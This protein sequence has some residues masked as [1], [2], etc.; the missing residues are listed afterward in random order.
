[1]TALIGTDP[2]NTFTSTTLKQ[3]KAFGL[4]DRYIDASGNEFVFVLASGVITVYDTVWINSAYTAAAI[5]PA[6]AVTPGAVGFAQTAFADG[7]Y[8]FVMTR[9]VPT[10]RVGAS[11]NA[12][13]PLYTS[14][15]A[16]VLDDS[17]LSASHYQVQGVILAQSV[18]ASIST[19]TAVASFPLIRRPQA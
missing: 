9:G 19:G 8:G 4:G 12:N 18:S 1:M 14:D 10:I 15:T 13:V 2:S 3:G 16:G 6:L 5:T 7:E 11:C 17:T